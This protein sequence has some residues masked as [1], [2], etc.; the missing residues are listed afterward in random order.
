VNIIVAENNNNKKQLHAYDK[1]QSES[2][3]IDEN[4]GPW[5]SRK[6]DRV[7]YAGL[8]QSEWPE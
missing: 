6:H 4:A 3:S 7:S 2:P 1:F 8:G 5:V